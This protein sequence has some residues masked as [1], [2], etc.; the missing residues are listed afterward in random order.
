MLN[1]RSEGD[2][3]ILIEDGVLAATHSASAALKESAMPMYVLEA[4]HNA[5]GLSGR[6]SEDFI[7]V[8]D[9]EFVQLCCKYT[10]TVSWF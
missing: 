4:D 2:A 9:D 6:I 5:R 8:N 1:A 10:K 7:V 3:C